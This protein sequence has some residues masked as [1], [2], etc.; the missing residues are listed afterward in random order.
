MGY[1]TA[2]NQAFKN[3][4][5]A[6]SPRSKIQIERSNDDSNFVNSG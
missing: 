5:S 1:S 6:Q 4:M 2:Y 3:P